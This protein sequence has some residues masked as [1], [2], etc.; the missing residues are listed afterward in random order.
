MAIW[1]T[2][3]DFVDHLV[4]NEDD[5]KDL[6]D[7]ELRLAAAA[8]LVRAM[9]IDGNCD[10]REREAIGKVLEQRFGLDAAQSKQL[11][12]EAEEKEH[13]AVDLYSFTSVITSQLDSEGRQKI[14]EM[15]WEIVMA[16]GEV[17]EFESN[18]IWRVAELLGVSSR[19]RI[20]LRKKVEQN[21]MKSV[22]SDG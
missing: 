2:V 19:D 1:K 14:V 4:Q 18:L 12:A 22:W 8:L 21:Q 9:V 7:E 10:D 6:E 16:D 15:L 11:V 13:E 5:A 20:K 17:H 3:K